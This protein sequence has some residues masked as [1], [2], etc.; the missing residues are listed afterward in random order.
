[1]KVSHIY[2]DNQKL[3]DQYFYPMRMH[4]GVKVLGTAV[5]AIVNKKI[6]KYQ[7]LC[8]FAICEHNKLVCRKLASLLSFESSGMAITCSYYPARMRKG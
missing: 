8:P 4:K 3:A 6:A 5:V 7:H 2:L 1:M